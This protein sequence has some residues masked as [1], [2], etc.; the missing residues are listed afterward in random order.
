MD[1]ETPTSMDIDKEKEIADLQHQLLAFEQ[2]CARIEKDYDDLKGENLKLKKVNEDL[3]NDVLERVKFSRILENERDELSLKIHQ[4]DNEN[5]LL[6]SK[7]EVYEGQVV[8]ITEAK[9]KFQEKI[10]ILT[11]D[12]NE[13]KT[14]N[15][16]LKSNLEKNADEARRNR[17]ERESWNDQKI[18]Y[19]NSRNWYM[20][21]IR[22]RDEALGSKSITISKLELQLQEVQ[23]SVNEREETLQQEIIE[24]KTQLKENDEN[25]K[26]LI[27]EGKKNSSE[28]S[29]LVASHDAIIDNKE[30]IIETLKEALDMEQKKNDDLANQCQA[31]EDELIESKNNFM[32]AANEL[33]GSRSEYLEEIRCKDE[34]ISDMK[35]EIVRLSSSNTGSGNWSSQ[36]LSE[37]NGDTTGA[38][39]QS[40]TLSSFILMHSHVAAER[41][42]LKDKVKYMEEK[43]NQFAE[44]MTENIKVLENQLIDYKETLLDNKS[45]RAQIGNVQEMLEDAVDTKDKLQR[46]LNYT[47]TQLMRY[48]VDS[49][50]LSK[51]VKRLLYMVESERKGFEA[52]EVEE[53]ESL[54][55]DIDSLQKVNSEL[56]SRLLLLEANKEEDLQKARE[57]EAEKLSAQ[58]IKAEEDLKIVQ[59]QMKVQT[60]MLKKIQEQRDHFAETIETY[61]KMGLSADAQ[62]LRISLDELKNEKTRLEA[63]ISHLEELTVTLN[64]QK[65]ESDKIYKERIDEQTKLIAELRGTVGKL[66]SDVQYLR[67]CNKITAQNTE[68]LERANNR[69]I[70]KIEALTR[71]NEKKFTEIGNL[72][73]K[74]IE[75]QEEIS[76]LKV[77]KRSLEDQNKILASSEVRLQT[78]NETLRGFSSRANKVE[79]AVDEIQDFIKKM[80]EDN[81]FNSQAQ[82]D[83]LIKQRDSINETFKTTMEQNNRNIN[84]LKA[85]IAK[86]EGDRK[87]Y[88]D[89]IK[90]METLLKEKETEIV[91]LKDKITFT[92]SQLGQFNDGSLTTEDYKG[93]VRK[94][95]T[96][97]AYLERRCA[98]LEELVNN[99]KLRLKVKD[100]QLNKISEFSEDVESALK[101]A[102]DLENSERN[103]LQEQLFLSEEELKTVKKNLEDSRSM[104]SSLETECNHKTTELENMS[105]KMQS[106][107]SQNESNFQN[108]NNLLET[109]VRDATILREEVD[110]LTQIKETLSET[111]SAFESQVTELE[112]TIESKDESL[113]KLEYALSQK[114]VSLKALNEE[115]EAYKNVMDTERD[116]LQNRIDEMIT[117]EKVKVENNDHMLNELRSL[118]SSFTE[119]REKN[120]LSC[121]INTSMS[122]SFMTS[123]DEDDSTEKYI[124]T[125]ARL[126]RMIECLQNDCQ[127]TLQRCANAECELTNVRSLLAVEKTNTSLLDAKVKELRHT[128]EIQLQELKD[129]NLLVQKLKVFDI[130]KEELDKVKGELQEIIQRCTELENQLK[131][132]EN[133]NLALES[134]NVVLENEKENLFKDLTSVSKERDS[135]KK[136]NERNLEILAKYGPS[137]CEMLVTEI[138]TAKSV[139]SKLKEENKKLTEEQANKSVDSSEEEGYKSKFIRVRKLARDYRDQA[140]ILKEKSERLEKI[141]EEKNNTKEGDN[142]GTIAELQ[143]QI[144]EKNIEI[145]NLNKEI[146]ILKEKIE[147]LTLELD[148]NS[149]IENL[150]QQYSNGLKVKENEIIELKEQVKELKSRIEDLLK[151]EK[152]DEIVEDSQ[153][154]EVL[155]NDDDADDLEAPTPPDNGNRKR[156]ISQELDFHDD[157]GEDIYDTHKKSKFDENIDI[158]QNTED[159]LEDPSV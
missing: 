56:R 108:L 91:N 95:G 105:I 27:K 44:S 48:Q 32:N 134:K 53:S 88:D 159:I 65:N 143:N 106:I 46:E 58:L 8:N 55:S 80:S 37:V 148:R 89:K 109:T 90:L 4:M 141:I 107:V 28:R 110:R 33:D 136:Q 129:K 132:K 10:E 45:L 52:S 140:Q 59:E 5:L 126:N 14:V 101:Q 86:L 23:A 130:T 142:D 124:E 34:M 51:Q 152:E 113:K 50:E 30:K 117:S 75:Y 13:L 25:I 81:I 12:I 22:D 40:R 149:L 41:D 111:I 24:L 61:N 137:K 87:I 138:E 84:D 133:I 49:Q 158:L 26:S 147:D 125:I 36:N 19:E 1:L 11:N 76:H 66:E 77:E 154:T 16:T 120:I 35:K 2:Q 71:E 92:E 128:I 7:I 145:E 97:K 93:E 150:A 72:N 98:E 127:S 68:A 18:L 42:N 17:L 156:G 43:M 54:F 135:W 94:M 103:R 85:N 31:L 99:Y 39:K 38:L 64:E 70:K 115:F 78:E 60:E 62:N 123:A 131:E 157:L 3:A 83:A 74:L 21:E 82:L 146:S 57:A 116:R 100:E 151:P 29:K 102:N 139:I 15:E 79:T 122:S 63:K 96:A 144:N 121:T 20:K 114:D 112:K 155:T 69:F 118:I 119:I 47:K 6:R 104:I 67:Q 73:R 9:E 153:E